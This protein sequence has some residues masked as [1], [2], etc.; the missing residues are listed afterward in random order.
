MTVRPGRADSVLVESADGTVER[1]AGRSLS[2]V[3]SHD[4][5]ARAG[6]VVRV[7]WTVGTGS[8]DG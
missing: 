7:D 5:F 3:Q 4:V 8:P 1:S 6:S 2:A